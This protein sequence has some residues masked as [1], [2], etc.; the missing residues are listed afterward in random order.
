M[1]NR[2]EKVHLAKAYVALSNSHNLNQIF[3]QFAPD[4]IYTSA[5]V[6]SF[7]GLVEI[8]VMMRNFFTTYTNVHW[9]SR[10][11]LSQEDETVEFKFVMTATNNKTGEN[12]L[13]RGIETIEYN[14]DGLISVLNVF[15]EDLSGEPNR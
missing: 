11:Y 2:S 9:D 4:A 13:R 3:L 1:Y 10:S 15:A 6:G 7:Q 12:I 14:N 5:H 8:K